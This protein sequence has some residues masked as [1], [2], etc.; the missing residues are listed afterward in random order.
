MSSLAKTLVWRF[1]FALKET[2]LA[3]ETLGCKLQGNYSFKEKLSRHSTLTQVQYKEPSLGKNTFIA[4]S[5]LV[6]GD[7]IIGDK[8]SVWYNAVVRGDHRPVTIG[9][10]SN[11]QDNVFVGSTSE[12]SPETFIGRNVSI[13]HGAVLKGCTI[14]DNVLVGMNAVISEK[15]TV[16]PNSVVA[17]GAYLPEEAVV[18]TG[19]VWAG[20]PARKL[21]D[22]RPKEIQYLSTLPER[23]VESSAEHS[24]MM[25]LLSL[26]QKEFIK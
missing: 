9:E 19:E 15:V 24:A 22:L 11:I 5:A 26:K 1:G 17:A 25:E 16:Q 7:V 13:G 3:L 21:R 23:Y 12:F 8:A 4:P 6:A 18:Q 2:G 10:N 14:G 20:S